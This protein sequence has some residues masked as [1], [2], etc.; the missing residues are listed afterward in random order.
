MYNYFTTSVILD[1]MHKRAASY[2]L[3][4]MFLFTC[5]HGHIYF[6]NRLNMLMLGGGNRPPRRLTPLFFCSYSQ[7]NIL[8]I[9]STKY[10]RMCKGPTAQKTK[11]TPNRS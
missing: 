10:T 8:S 4:Y 7:T 3:F 11:P 1:Q 6:F 9:L 2:F 5:T